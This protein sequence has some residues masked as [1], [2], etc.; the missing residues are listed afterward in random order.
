LASEMR[1][2]K[3]Y[4]FFMSF[5]SLVTEFAHSARQDPYAITRFIRTTLLPDIVLFQHMRSGCIMTCII[6]QVGIQVTPLQH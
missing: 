2:R 6:L 1:E 4:L 5:H 3:E